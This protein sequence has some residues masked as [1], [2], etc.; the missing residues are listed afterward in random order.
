MAKNEYVNNTEGL[1]TGRKA[2]P[3]HRSVFVDIISGFEGPSDKIG[4]KARARYYTYEPLWH[5]DFMESLDGV[6]RGT[7]TAA[8]F[9]D[10]YAETLQY[11]LQEMIDMYR[12]GG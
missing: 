9:A 5:T 7:Q 3:E 11:A 12:S 8:Q 1:L 2:N 6:W 4:G 10:G